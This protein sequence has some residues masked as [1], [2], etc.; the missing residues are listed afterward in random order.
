LSRVQ[1]LGS[2]PGRQR[3]VDSGSDPPSRLG[4]GTLAGAGICGHL[5]AVL[6]PRFSQVRLGLAITSS[7]GAGRSDRGGAD[8]WALEPGFSQFFV[9]E[10]RKKPS[11]P[12]DGGPGRPYHNNEVG[13]VGRRPAGWDGGSADGPGE[14]LRC[15]SLRIASCWT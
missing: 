13:G 7:N 1:R 9:E 8:R 11:D 12:I 3:S 6:A 4:Y 14:G 2:G 5:T 15:P 10:K